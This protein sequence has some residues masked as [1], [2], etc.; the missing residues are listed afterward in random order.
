MTPPFR[1]ACTDEDRKREERNRKQQEY[2]AR[3]RA[4]QTD[5]EREEINRKAR[6][7]RAQRKAESSALSNPP[8]QTR[9]SGGN[10]TLF[11]TW[12]HLLAA[13]LVFNYA[14]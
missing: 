6:E 12:L 2:R 8:D 14:P 7:Y 5:E 13:H 10:N 3:R 9:S 11:R 1:T 4:E